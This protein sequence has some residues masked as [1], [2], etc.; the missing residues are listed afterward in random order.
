MFDNLKI[1]TRVVLA[2]GAV[3]LVVVALG[4]FNASRLREARESSAA[5]QE[6]GM[7]P[8]AEMDAFSVAFYRSWVDI[9]NGA[10]LNDIPARAAWLDK[11]GHRVG[12]ADHAL[13]QLVAAAKGERAHALA[14]D[15]AR[16]FRALRPEIEA[17]A[18]TLRHS[19]NRPVLASLL[20]GTLY[21]Q[22]HDLTETADRLSAELVQSAKARADL[23]AARAAEAIQLSVGLMIAAAALA[24][25]LGWLL[26]RYLGRIIRAM[27]DETDGL[28]QAAVDGKLATRAHPERVS[29]EF[30]GVIDG[31]NRV[32]DALTK[33]LDMAAS[34]LA[35]IA[36]GDIPSRISDSYS[37]DFNAIKNNLNTCIDAVNAL[38]ADASM[39]AAA[40]AEGTLGVRADANR[41]RGDFRRVITGV[42]GALDAVVGPLTTAAD[43]IA[44]VA[45]GDLPETITAAY[46]GD[47]NAIKNNLNSLVGSMR[48]V[49]SVCQEMAAG[50]VGVDV[51]ERS[52]R[53]ELMRALAGMVAATQKVTRL[54][55]EIAGGNLLVEIRPRSD[56]DELM[57]ALAAMTK[58]LSAI[59]MDVRVSSENVAAG[60]TELNA[61]A[62]ELSR[63]AT[64]QASSIEEVSSSMEQ[65]SANARQNADNAAQTEKIANKAAADAREG[66][67][68]VGQTLDA[69]KKIANKISIIDE[70]ARQ[71]N[72]LALNAAIEAARAGEHGKGFAVVASE[73]RK[74]AERSQ[75]A[76]GEITELSASSVGV[77]E[78]AG[79]LLAKILPDVQRTA[80]LV[81]EITAASR[82]QDTGAEQITLALQQLDRVIQQ[83]AAA[84]E[85][86]SA[87]SEQLTGQA[88]QLRQSITYF[89]LEVPRDASVQ[90]SLR[91]PEQA[92]PRA[93][94]RAA[95]KPAARAA[96][97][98]AVAAAK[99]VAAGPIL[100]LSL[101]DAEDA[102]FEG[103]RAA[104]SDT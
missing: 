51:R 92:P 85:Q 42:N 86:T 97:D 95:R 104:G 99:G 76:A 13:E 1:G 18:E 102:A 82:E 79:S 48:T 103:Y 54:S 87:T 83:N 70:I 93:P 49:T 55:Q 45:R 58:K 29:L 40:A 34:N 91:Q 24:G 78:K 21:R 64:E 44:R 68:A 5:L 72:L 7:V 89:R 31:L 14:T 20:G 84:S 6:N 74:L 90:P 80:E 60:A 26:A 27:Q 43:H 47:F 12:E 11:V 53:D 50:K 66:G 22:R 57:N 4:G 67:I 52:D 2:L 28:V 38:V 3:V 65:M 98:P 59:V 37:G 94:S 62:E 35:R 46:Q 77:A 69:M 36:N 30:R 81:Q 10:S 63:G 73:V 15:L 56:G 61:S 96:G 23:T 8:L 17:A 25:L 9:M 88:D 101:G 33:P 41:H 39:L 16:L 32:L 100:D 75:K 71:T 19:D